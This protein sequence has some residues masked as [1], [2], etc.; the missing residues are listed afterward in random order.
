MHDQT[1]RGLRTRRISRRVQAVAGV[2]AMGL[3]AAG[4]TIGTPAGA[5]T[6]PHAAKLPHATKFLACE[7][8][9]IGGLGD[10]SFNYSA[11]Q[12]LLQAQKSAGGSAKMSIAVQQTPPG[13]GESNYEAEIQK[14]INE[15]CNIIVT[16][17]FL[18]DEATAKAANA[19]HS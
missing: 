12:G 5:Q 18:M 2:G 4:L 8:T 11:Y 3:L 15:K 13:G 14:F 7:V 19:H 17:G 16:V 9:D 6:S 10:K 1:G